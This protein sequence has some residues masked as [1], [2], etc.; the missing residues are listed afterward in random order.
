MND[1]EIIRY[2]DCDVLHFAIKNGLEISGI[3]P[4]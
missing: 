3:K 1:S 4:Y 2:I